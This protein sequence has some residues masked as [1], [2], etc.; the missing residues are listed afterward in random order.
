MDKD[1]MNVKIIISAVMVQPGMWDTDA[2]AQYAIAM[3][4][5]DGSIVWHRSRD[6]RLYGMQYGWSRVAKI[7]S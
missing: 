3:D 5:P 7:V 6:W 4:A 2:H 1:R